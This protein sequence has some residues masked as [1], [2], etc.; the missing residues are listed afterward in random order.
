MEEAKVK[1][2][3][4]TLAALNK[5]EG[6]IINGEVRGVVMSG[7]IAPDGYAIQFADGREYIGKLTDTITVLRIV[8]EEKDEQ[9]KSR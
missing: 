9:N 8:R 6:I 1:E 3:I 7:A 4:E 2:F 5:G